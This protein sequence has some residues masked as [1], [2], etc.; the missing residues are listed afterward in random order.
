MY[1]AW[2]LYNTDFINAQQAKLAYRYSMCM[3]HQ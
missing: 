3:H 2:K 1:T